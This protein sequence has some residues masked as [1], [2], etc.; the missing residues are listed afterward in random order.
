MHQFE[1][2]YWWL[3]LLPASSR[4]WFI[5]ML[6]NPLLVL[7]NKLCCLRLRWGCRLRGC[8]WFITSF[9]CC[10]CLRKD[11]KKALSDNTA[12]LAA[13]VYSTVLPSDRTCQVCSP[14]WWCHSSAV[15]NQR[16]MQVHRNCAR[17]LGKP[18]Q[19]YTHFRK[20]VHQTAYL[21][22][23]LCQV[24]SCLL[25]GLQDSSILTVKHAQQQMW[26]TCC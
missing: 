19:Q 6:C 3:P 21:A 12:V 23:E 7:V 4:W 18:Y 24:N 2:A 13:H 15:G 22:S 8:C 16:R 14:L 25:K 5:P 9:G 17:C 26:S 10:F 1:C 20:Q 11:S